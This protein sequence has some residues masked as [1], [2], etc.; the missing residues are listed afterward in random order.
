MST[1]YSPQLVA[2]ARDYSRRVN[3]HDPDCTRGHARNK[4]CGD[5]LT[6]WLKFDHENRISKSGYDGEG[7]ALALASSSAI[8]SFIEGASKK[9]AVDI[10]LNFRSFIENESVSSMETFAP[11]EPIKQIKQR[12]RCVTLI[13]EALFDALI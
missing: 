12:H 4:N 2:W 6:V 3:C 10:L 13:T 9:E 11:F 7:C 5:E 8:C 1:P